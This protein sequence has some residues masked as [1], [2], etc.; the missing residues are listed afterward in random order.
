MRI[1]FLGSGAFGLPTLGAL[2]AS[3]DHEVTLVVSQPDRPAGRGLKERPTPVAE[4]ARARGLPLR[5]TPTRSLVLHPPR[6]RSS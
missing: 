1:A 3:G 4:F 5:R 6:R 2:L